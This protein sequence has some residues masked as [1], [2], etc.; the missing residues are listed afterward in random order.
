MTA[1]PDCD[2][3]LGSLCC[4]NRAEHTGGGLGCTHSAA[5]LADGHDATEA[6]DE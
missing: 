2:H 1:A 4:D 6:R 3:F 5:W